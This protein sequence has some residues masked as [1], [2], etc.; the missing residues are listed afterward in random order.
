MIRFPGIFTPFVNVQHDMNGRKTS[1]NGKDLQV[2]EETAADIYKPDMHSTNSTTYPSNVRRYVSFL[3]L[4]VGS[5]C[6][7]ERRAR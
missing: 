1:Y 2:N 3:A 6:S 4:S 7:C 5:G